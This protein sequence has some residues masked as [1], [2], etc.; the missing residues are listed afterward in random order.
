[1][2][3]NS[4]NGFTL[5]EL[6][7]VISIIGTLSTIAMTSLNG[8]R[9]KARD[10]KRIQEIE[11]IQSALEIY[12][13]NHGYYP[14]YNVN[15]IA[16]CNTDTALNALVTEGFF[17]SIP[18]DPLNTNSSSPY[19]CY[20][21]VGADAT[22]HYAFTTGWYCDGRLRTDY[23]WSFYF[24]TEATR[25]NFSISSNSLYKYCIHGPLL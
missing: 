21:Y 7:V 12:Y 1:M 6:L 25:A 3:N 18:V 19:Y 22:G 23:Q 9:T 4:K 15:T 13:A 5:I 24:S 14:Q 2:Y 16:H 17:S 8:A 10:A 11:Q 20:T